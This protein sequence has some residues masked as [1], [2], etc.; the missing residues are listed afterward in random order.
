MEKQG[1]ELKKLKAR[2]IEIEAINRD[3]S[4]ANEK[5]TQASKIME[6]DSISLK[7]NEKK[8][9]LIFEKAPLGIFHFNSKGEI[10]ECNDNFVKI[11]GS[12]R[13]ILTGLNMFTLPDNRISEALNITIREQIPAFL[14]IEYKS[15]TAD[16][17]TPVKILFAPLTDE[18]T[19]NSSGGIGIVEDI[20]ARILAEENLRKSETRYRELIDFAVDG[21][22]TGSPEGI[23]TSANRRIIEIAGIPENEVIGSHV[24][25]LFP[26]EEL[27]SKPLRF[28]LLQKGK[29]IVNSRKLLRPDESEVYIE[30]HS[31]MMPDKSYHSIIRDVTERQKKEEELAAEKEQLAVTLKS[32]GEAVITTDTDCNILIMNKVAENLTGWTQDEARGRHL[33]EVLKILDKKTADSGTANP[34]ASVLE[35][36][37][38]KE[39]AGNAILIS[40]DGIERL[41]TD[42]AAPIKDIHGNITGVVLVLRDITEKQKL[43]DSFQNSQKLESLGILAGGIAHDFNN[44]LG[45]ILSNI[46]LAR[47]KNCDSNLTTYLEKAIGTIDR[48]RGLTR[49]L[50]TFASGGDPVKKITPLLPLIMDTVNF[51]LSGSKVSPH[52]AVSDDLHQSMIDKAQIEQVIENIVINALQSMPMGGVIEVAANNIKASELPGLSADS[53]YIKISISDQGVGIPED[54]IKHIFDPFFTT[55]AKGHGLGLATSYSIISRHNGSIEVKSKPGEGSKFYIYLPAASARETLIQE[56]SFIPHKGEGSILVMD[57][58]EAIRDILSNMLKHLG[59]TPVCARDGDEALEMLTKKFSKGS[60]L[61]AIILDLTVPGGM[62]G[63]KTVKEIRKF[64]TGIPVFV[65]SG[66]SEDPAI[67]RPEEFGF[68]DSIRKPF[69]VQELADMLRRNRV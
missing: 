14:E 29:T 48:A 5:L 69:Q 45:G 58:E 46:D 15:F 36:C 9:R 50:L 53:D 54:I 52:F 27:A 65:S 4:A 64:N 17:T 19:S 37:E 56:D 66:Y 44:L 55:K 28:D 32:I 25:K 39:L 33:T 49:Q 42:S 51:A 11:I 57:D 40:R 18:I 8:F 43:I 6:N 41:I 61:S 38:I 26:R 22:I 1:E 3:L 2:F 20:S 24:S 31:K 60:D 59:Y 13:E 34:A 12:S 10:T 47:I 67:S 62:G 30:M 23:I 7:E 21:I 63:E 68:S 16:K 35:S